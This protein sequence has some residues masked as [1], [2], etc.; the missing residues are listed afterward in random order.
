V[1]YFYRSW[2]AGTEFSRESQSLRRSGYVP[3]P[4]LRVTFQ[5]TNAFKHLASE[6][7]VSTNLDAGGGLNPRPLFTYLSGSTG[8]DSAHGLAINGKTFA[9]VTGPHNF[10]R[11]AYG[12]VDPPPLIKV[13]R[14]RPPE[15]FFRQQIDTA[16]SGAPRSFTHHFVGSTPNDAS[17]TAESIAVDTGATCTHGRKTNFLFRRPLK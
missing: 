8:V 6:P 10:H 9:Y 1:I 16:G 17:L 13:A 11:S 2:R 3:E 12:S 5:H 14:T 4:P 15:Q 7:H